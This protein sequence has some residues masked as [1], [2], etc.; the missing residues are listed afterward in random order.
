[1]RRLILA[2]IFLLAWCLIASA[3]TVDTLQQGSTISV[4]N[5][6]QQV[7]AR[8]DI[9][10]GCLLQNNGTHNML[11]YFGPIANATTSN[12][13]TLLANAANSISCWT[14]GGAFIKSQ[15]SITGTA[16]DAYVFSEQ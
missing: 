16:G 2:S 10:R 3:Q 5:T 12:G 6:Y 1:M 8:S 7:L 15:V 14:G 4:T 13:L 11:V 9:R